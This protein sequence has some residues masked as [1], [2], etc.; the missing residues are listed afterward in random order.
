[1][2]FKTRHEETWPHADM[3]KWR[4]SLAASSDHCEDSFF[5]ICKLTG[6]GFLKGSRRGGIWIAQSR[7]YRFF[8]I[9]IFH[10][11]SQILSLATNTII[12][13]PQKLQ[14]WLH[15]F[16][17]KQANY[18]ITDYPSLN[19]HSTYISHSFK[20]KMVSCEKNGW[21]SPNPNNCQRFS[22]CSIMLWQAAEMFYLYIPFH[23]TKYSKDRYSRVEI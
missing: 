4:T 19:N 15:C 12:C 17:N 1:M 5:D 23:Q 8:K 14:P 21:S 9:L 18:L 16:K 6:G 11:N 13:F 10:L 2:N 3:E 7:E 20:G 22:C